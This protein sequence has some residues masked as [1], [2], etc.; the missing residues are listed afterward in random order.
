M[1]KV[2]V[3]EFVKRK[4]IIRSI[5]GQL[6]NLDG[7]LISPIPSM[8]LSALPSASSVPIG[9]LVNIPRSQFKYYGD[10]ELISMPEWG[11]D[12]KSNGTNWRT[13]N[14]QLYAE[15][16][17]TKTLPLVN[18]PTGAESIQANVTLP[19]GNI[20]I[21][22]ELLHI[23]FK[24]TIES[25][26]GKGATSGA[27]SNYFTRIGPSA[28]FL[29]NPIVGYDTVITG[30]SKQQMITTFINFTSTTKITYSDT[31]PNSSAGNA[32][33]G[34]LGG[35][36]DAAITHDFSSSYKVSFSIQPAVGGG[37]NT[38]LMFGYRIFLEV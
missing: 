27:A 26:W 1:G 30:T 11:I 22:P 28:T 38:D 31:I 3:K 34:A 18:I 6:A 25:F 7:Q 20:L 13:P 2:S 12:L 32:T 21:P 19:N 35:Y 16:L 15:E 17:S 23:G 29:N 5:N 24:M 36:M 9:T 33:S 4:N 8:A 14:K 37:T 10:A